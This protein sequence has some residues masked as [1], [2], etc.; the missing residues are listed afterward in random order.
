MVAASWDECPLPEW[1]GTAQREAALLREAAATLRTSTPTAA[2]ECSF[3]ESLDP[4]SCP[5]CEKPWSSNPAD[6]CAVHRAF[7]GSDEQREAYIRSLLAT[8]TLAGTDRRIGYQAQPDGTLRRVVAGSAPT[9][10][11]GATMR[12]A[13]ERLRILLDWRQEHGESLTRAFRD[14]PERPT[15]ADLRLIADG[16][17]Q[18]QPSEVPELSW[19]RPKRETLTLPCSRCARQSVRTVPICVRCWH[20]KICTPECDGWGCRVPTCAAPQQEET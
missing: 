14:A 13:L 19:V 16:A 12:E 11:D 3:C 18:Q 5:D 15:V 1:F 8:S 9:A 2:R 4:T 10:Q 7:I 17:Q 20:E 6:Y